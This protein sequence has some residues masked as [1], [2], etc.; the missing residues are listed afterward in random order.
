MGR[1]AAFRWSGGREVAARLNMRKLSHLRVFC[2]AGR[3]LQYDG[4]LNAV[5]AMFSCR[6]NVV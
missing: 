4:R 3:P 5:L 2:G 1:V 6:L